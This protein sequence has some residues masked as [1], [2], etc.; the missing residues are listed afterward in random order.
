MSELDLKNLTTPEQSAMSHWSWR[1]V[2]CVELEQG[3]SENKH[4]LGWATLNKQLS[5]RE[6]QAPQHSN[7]WITRQR[8]VRYHYLAKCIN[9]HPYRGWAVPFLHLEKELHLIP[10]FCALSLFTFSLP[11]TVVIPGSSKAA[12][13]GATMQGFWKQREWITWL[14]VMFCKLVGYRDA[15]QLF[16]ICNL[17]LYLRPTK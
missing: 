10:A 12:Q 13:V 6:H 9:K 15:G 11:F 17:Q 5:L 8:G 7:Q 16:K 3:L 14:S 4:L 1:S 2:T